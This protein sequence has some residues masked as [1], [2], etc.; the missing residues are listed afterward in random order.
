MR[1]A[2]HDFLILPWAISLL[3]TL[4]TELSDNLMS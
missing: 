2:E 3:S 4:P 1:Q